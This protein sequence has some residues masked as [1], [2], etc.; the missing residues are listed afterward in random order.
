MSCVPAGNAVAN[1]GKGCFIRQIGLLTAFHILAG[2]DAVADLVLTQ[3]YHVGDTQLIGVIHLSLE[4]LLL[5]IQL[6]ADTGRAKL[7][8]QCHSGRQ[9]LRHGDDQHIRRCGGQRIVQHTLLA[10]HVEQAGQADGDAHAGQLLVGVVFRQI[11]IPSAGANG[12]NLGMI[13]Q[14]SFVHGTRVVIQTAGDGQIH[15]EILL[16]HAKG[17]QIAN[18][19]FQFL[20]TQIEKFIPA[21]V[22][23]Q[24]REHLRIGAADGNEGQ[25]LIRLCLAQSDLV[26]QERTHLIGADLLQLIHGAHNIAGLLAEIVHSVKS[27]QNLAVVDA[28]LETA[29]TQGSKGL[30]N[31]GGDFRLVGHVQL[32]VADDIDIRL[33]KLTETTALCP[34]TAVHLADLIPTEGECQLTV[35]ESHILGQRHGQ[36]KPQTQIRVPLLETVHLFFRFAAALGKQN[37]SRFDHGRIQ[38]SKAV[39]GVG[40]T[41]N[42]HNPLHLLLGTGKQFHK[43]G[44]R[45]GA[46]PLC[47]LVLFHICSLPPS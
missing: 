11:V 45:A 34:L 40:G 5:G 47:L 6:C 22:T 36:I 18:Y 27:V 39:A 33:I 42:F 21:G 26:G 15:R 25:N 23:F 43:A 7:C 35:V 9:I 30:I 28:D 4:L 32:A 13:D 24:C 12:A 19:G 3:E 20:Q 38:G 29:Q 46:D 41:E 1:A 44:Q 17:R 10:Q 14:G 16:R 31:D 8:G 2:H 37:V